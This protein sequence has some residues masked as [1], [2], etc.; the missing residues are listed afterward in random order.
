MI[1][2]LNLTIYIAPKA[3]TK[4]GFVISKDTLD[5][6][7]PFMVA[8][9]VIDKIYKR[10]EARQYITKVIYPKLPNFVLDDT[11]KYT[12]FLLENFEF[13][14]DI[15]ENGI[16]EDDEFHKWE[17][18]EDELIPPKVDSYASDS[19]AVTQ[20]PVFGSGFPDLSDIPEGESDKTHRTKKSLYLS[21]SA[22]ERL[23]KAGSSIAKSPRNID[24]KSTTSKKTSI[25]KFKLNAKNHLMM[26]PEAIM[27][28]EQVPIPEPERPA[29]KKEVLYR[30]KDGSE[31]IKQIDANLLKDEEDDEEVTKL[32]DRLFQE[33]NS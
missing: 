1:K 19:A 3:Q 32:R 17:A 11:L 8:N 20:V 26:S 16:D 21:I 2:I 4:P 31:T 24:A 5:F 18:D 30:N 9:Y 25:M 7:A 33:V 13:P 12:P 15:G 23:D 6:A 14:Y 22:I 10:F 28:I 27:E 29:S